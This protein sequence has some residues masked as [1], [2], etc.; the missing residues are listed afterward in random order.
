MKNPGGAK[1]FR[2]LVEGT[3]HK[4]LDGL[5]NLGFFTSYHVV[6]D[7]A[8]EAMKFLKRFEPPPVRRSL[9]MHECEQLDDWPDEPKGV[10]KTFAYQFFRRGEDDANHDN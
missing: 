10:Y 3:W 2:I 7:D 8:A 6:A 1:Y 4:S 5:S 9:V